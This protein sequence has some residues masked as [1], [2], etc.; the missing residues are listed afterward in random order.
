MKVLDVNRRLL[1][2][3]PR[4]YAISLLLQIFRLG[5]MLAPGLV[6]RVIFD[7]LAGTFQLGWVFWGLI[8]LIVVIAV[9][10]L[11]ALMGGVALERTGYFIASGLLRTNL[12]EHLL[13]RPDA[14]A[15]LYPAGDLINRLDKDA[16]TIADLLTM[17]ILIIGGSVGSLIAVGLMVSI[18]PLIT[19]IVLVP[20]VLAGLASSM[21]GTHMMDYRRCARQADGKVSAFLGEI[22]SAVQAIQVATAEEHATKRLR[23]LNTTRRN[24]AIAERLFAYIIFDRFVLGIAQL[25]VGLVILL[26][27]RSMR[28]GT[29][30]IGD[31]ALFTYALQQVADF[32]WYLGG[33]LLYLKQTRVSLDRLAPLLQGAEATTMVQSRPVPFHSPLPDEP[34]VPSSIHQPLDRLTVRGL[35]YRYPGTTQGIE[36]INLDLPAGSFTV[37]TG[38]IGSGKTTLLRTLLGL[39]PMDTGEIRWNDQLVAHPATFFVPPHSAYTAQVPRLFSDTLRENVLLGRHANAAEM[40]SAVHL[41]VMEQDVAALSDGLDTLVGRRGV[42]LSGGQVQ[43]AAAARM[44]VRNTD[45]LVFDDLSSALD[46]ETEHTLWDNLFRAR[47]ATYLVV[48]H[49]RAALQRADHII[50]LKDGRIVAEGQLAWL[51]EN[52]DEMQELWRQ[53]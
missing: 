28:T 14:R 8:A 26:A 46:V 36:A 42:K 4:I 12:F 41:A 13:L 47:H 1:R 38:R 11:V 39:L 49:R 18:D 10:R 19:V 17:E 6:L 5:L 9:A 51:L 37:I 48:S 16:S 29:F 22:F 25:G 21:L 40:D 53:S 15:L 30:T 32:A 3:S 27:G 20:I 50:V 24:T 45:L 52:S 2:F 35:S 43:R 34:S 31:F 44:F 23:A 33:V 7:R